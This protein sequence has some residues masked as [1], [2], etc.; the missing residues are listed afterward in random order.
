[1]VSMSILEACKFA[2]NVS[3]AFC[4]VETKD[5]YRYRPFP[6]RYIHDGI[7]GVQGIEQWS[8]NIPKPAWIKCNSLE[9]L[10]N[11]RLGAIK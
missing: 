10:F 3:G 11:F 1:M 5:L 2:E 8:C 9:N 6:N 4:F 7:D